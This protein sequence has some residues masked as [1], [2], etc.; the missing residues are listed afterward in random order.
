MESPNIQKIIDTIADAFSV[1]DFSYLVSGIATLLLICFEVS[2]HELVVLGNLM[3]Y[4]YFLLI[5]IGVYISGLVSWTIGKAIRTKYLGWSCKK[6]GYEK[7]AITTILKTF[8]QLQILESPKECKTIESVRFKDYISYIWAVLIKFSIKDD[9]QAQLKVIKREWV[10]EAVYEGLAF[11]SILLCIVMTDVVI[12]KF[13]IG[14]N[15]P[16]YCYL[17]II[18]GTIILAFILLSTMLYKATE[19]GR[20]YARD[21]ICTYITYIDKPIIVKDLSID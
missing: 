17:I 16:W 5:P 2:K 13:S 7:D 19:S 11:S 8:E 12:S 10:M 14:A 20:A 21:L 15:P 3:T 6:G 9:L 18:L 1:F 4:W